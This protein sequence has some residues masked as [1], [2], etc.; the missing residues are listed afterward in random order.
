MSNY[1][2]NRDL[3]GNGFPEKLRQLRETA[4]LSQSDLAE[5]S[6]LT[7]RTIHDLELGKRTRSQEKTLLLLAGALGVTLDELIGHE[8]KTEPELVLPRQRKMKRGFVI[9]FVVLVIGAISMAVFWQQCCANADWDFKDYKLVV[10]DQLFGTVLW[11]ISGH[12]PLVT[13]CMNSPWNSHHLLVGTSRFASGGGSLLCL[14]RATGDTVWVAKPDVKRLVKA[15]GAEMVMSA[16]FSNRA[17]LVADLDGDGS[18]EIVTQFSHGKYFPNAICIIKSDGTLRA[19][20][21]HRGHITA[22]T[23]HDIDADGKEEIIC[24]GTNNSKSNMGA[25]VFILDDLHCNGTSRDSQTSPAGSEPD[26]AL[27]R[28]ILPNYPPPYM[29]L[30]K[31]RQLS[32]FGPQLFTNEIGEKSLSVIVHSDD[33]MAKVTVFLDSGL[34]PIKAHA[35][36]SFKQYFISQWPDS[37]TTDVGPGDAKWLAQWLTQYKRFGT[38]E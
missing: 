17:S 13:S 14:E 9:G 26:S 21:A 30:M 27:V 33:P 28:I 11:E 16:Q 20:Y 5:K 15:F 31:A 22:I 32:A 36:D 8:P 23:E 7:Y 34:R 12:E 2:K 3:S 18:P 1:Q 4:H 6:G 29:A 35:D 24:T 25:T 10:R 38:G 19:Q 37:L